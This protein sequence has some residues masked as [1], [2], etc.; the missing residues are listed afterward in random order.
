MRA[1]WSRNAVRLNTLTRAPVTP[2]RSRFRRRRSRARKA[3]AVVKVITAATV[4]PV[5]VD[6]AKTFLRVDTDADD[7]LIGA[8]ITAAR[9]Y[10]EH[11]TQ[12]TY[13]TVEYESA[14]D[15]FPVDA[16]TLPNAVSGAT[17]VE[18]VT[19]LDA[20]GD[21]QTVDAADYV[22]S[23][24]GMSPYIYP[25]P[26]FSWPAAGSFPNAVRVRYTVTVESPPAVAR[27]AMLEMVA[28]LYEAR[29]DGGEPPQ[30]VRRLLDVVKVY[31]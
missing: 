30:S 28:H 1:I 3:N 23:E 20:A 11:Y 16:I 12:S 21:L 7:V 19:Y 13:A 29:E 14:L 10:A 5:T 18:S 24:Y 2:K 25:D 26:V 4:E 9:E 22:L 6:E 8:L 15:A 27:V 17:E 31:A